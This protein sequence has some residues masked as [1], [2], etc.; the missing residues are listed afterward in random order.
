MED[1]VTRGGANGNGNYTKNERTSDNAIDKTVEQREQAPGGVESL[2]VGVVLDS[3]NQGAATTAQV[4]P[5]TAAM[6]HWTPRR[7]ALSGAPS[8]RASSHDMAKPQARGRYSGRIAPR[9]GPPFPPTTSRS[10]ERKAMALT[11][12]S[13]PTVLH[14]P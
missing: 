11:W 12:N 7:P 1:T 2:H 10:G 13:K 8:F 14:R 6:A 5:A 3:A 9:E 4:N